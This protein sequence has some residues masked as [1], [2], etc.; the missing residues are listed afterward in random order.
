MSVLQI[1]HVHILASSTGSVGK[2][3][4]TQLRINCCPHNEIGKIRDTAPLKMP[5]PVLNPASFINVEEE[6][7]DAPQR[8]LP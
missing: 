1:L 4:A 6:A 5:K 8:F 7:A 3:W 2:F